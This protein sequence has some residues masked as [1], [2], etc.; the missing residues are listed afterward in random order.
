MAPKTAIRISCSLRDYTGRIWSTV[1]VIF[2]DNQ[3]SPL[4]HEVIDLEPECVFIA[5]T[6]FELTKSSK[7]NC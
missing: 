6:V 4:V 1:P 7:A 3:D 2:K 5:P